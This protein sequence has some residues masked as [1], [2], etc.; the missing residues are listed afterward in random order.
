MTTYREVFA[1]N[2]SSGY[3]AD[4]LDTDFGT[5]NNRYEDS[6]VNLF[7]P[8]ASD[9]VDG[10]FLAST[11]LPTN[12]NPAY[13]TSGFIAVSEGDVIVSGNNGTLL[14]LAYFYTYD[15]DK[16]KNGGSFDAARL[17]Y[18]IP[19][20]VSYVR[21]S[22]AHV[23][24]TLY[25]LQRRG[26]IKPYT[27]YSYNLAL[28]PQ[29]MVLADDIVT[30]D[31]ILD[32]AVLEDKTIFFDASKNL[33]D[34]DS[35]D[36]VDGY[37]I[38]S[39]GNPTAN[40]NYNISAYIPAVEGQQFTKNFYYD[41]NVYST[42]Y[43]STKTVIAGSAS[44]AQTITAPADTAYFRVS[45]LTASNDVYQVELGTAET[46]YLKYGY[47]I[48]EN[49][50]D[51]Y[52]PTNE[53]KKLD[54]ILGQ[55]GIISTQASVADAGNITITDFPYY[56]KK[57]ISM[58][59]YCELTLSGSV[60]FGKGFET[61]A[62]GYFKIDGTNVYHLNYVTSEEIKTTTAHGL[63]IDT[64]LKASFF[65]D[66]DGI[67]HFILQSLTGYFETT[68]AYDSNL[69]AEP[70]ILTTGQAITNVKLTCTSKEFQHPIWS[71]GDSYMSIAST[72]WPFVMKEFGYFNFLIN[73]LPGQG[74]V[75]A[76]EELERCL[77]YGTPKYLFWTLG[78]ND[79]DGTFALYFPRVIA[80]CKLLGITLILATVPTVPERD[81]ETINAAIK[82]TGNRYVDFYE[83]VGA[84]SS[85][86]WYTGYLED[87]LTG[88]HPTV[89][90]SEA[91]ATQVL[92]DFPEIMQYGKTF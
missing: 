7:N 79:D 51:K 4:K 40:A 60:T 2:D 82:A 26:D 53:L 84:D 65:M 37:F 25:Q 6:S 89:L 13:F 29:Y 55:N 80:K 41:S 33:F 76:L 56:L 11:G 69:A 63:A 64:F 1:G 86:N 70:F 42:F 9:A 43:D 59:F 66:D 54:S 61:Y 14:A 15:S 72:R 12:E 20:G 62:G 49:Y 8:D 21:V 16:I 48:K 92:V 68:F 52:I 22:F 50:V 87:V 45:V 85:G 31:K 67:T 35:D 47:S 88:V 27:A 73:A 58:S 39:N 46:D 91:L 24:Y 19:S 32:E 81:K 90:G 10:Y 3:L 18:E 36:V 38:L 83:A 30:T 5:I 75:Y 34:P 71:F 57:G 28:K 23:V 74:T 77:L 44:N 78:M 17:S